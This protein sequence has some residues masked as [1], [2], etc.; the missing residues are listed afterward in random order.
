MIS[1]FLLIL[2][3]NINFIIYY[4]LF[5]I[6]YILIKYLVY[7]PICLYYV[8]RFRRNLHNVY[9]TINFHCMK[10]LFAFIYLASLKRHNF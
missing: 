10:T 4:L 8:L 3:F 6:Y 7:L 1:I 5:M 2:Y 9:K